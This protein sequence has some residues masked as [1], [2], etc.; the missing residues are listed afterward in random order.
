MLDARGVYRKVTR[1]IYD[2]S[3]EQLQNLLSI[4][5]LYRGENERFRTLVASHLQQMGK[6]SAAITELLQKFTESINAVLALIR[7]FLVTLPKDGAHREPQKEFEVAL[8]ILGHDVKDY[9]AAIKN[10]PSTKGQDNAKAL[11]AATAKSAPVA[12]QSRDLAKQAEH[13]FKLLGRLIDVCEKETQRQRTRELEC[14]GY[15]TCAEDLR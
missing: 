12:E 2:F 9:Q 10:L 14:S 3:P 4:V 1:K 7:P 6:E 15:W 11:R 5:W 8:G 13:T